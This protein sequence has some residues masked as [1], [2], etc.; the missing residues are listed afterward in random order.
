MKFGHTVAGRTCALALA[1]ALAACSG[2]NGSADTRLVAGIDHLSKR[3]LKA[4]VIEFKAAL[5]EAPD[6]PRTRFYLGRALLMSGDGVSAVVELRKALDLGHARAEVLPEL[7]RAMLLAGQPKKLLEELGNTD[8]GDGLEGADL[9]T[10]LASA[11]AQVGNIEQAAASLAVVLRQ[12]PDLPAAQL[13]KARFQL[14]DNLPDAA[15]ALAESV[16]RKEPANVDAHMLLGDIKLRTKGDLAGAEAAYQAALRADMNSLRAHSALITLYLRQKKLD[17]AHAQLEKLKLAH[18]SQFQTRLHEA[19]IAALDH[20]FPVARE[21]LQG[22]L[23]QAPESTD[24]LRLAGL[25]ESNMGNVRSARNYFT[26]AL[27]ND[28]A[29]VD[30]RVLLADNYLQTNQPQQA[31]DFLKDGLANERAPAAVLELAAK[32]SMQ[33]GDFGRARELFQ[34]ANKVTPTNTA[35]LTS[36]AVLDSSTG[37]VGGAM[38]QLESISIRDADTVADYALIS[39][40]VKQADFDG[41]LRAI[42]AMKAKNVKPAALEVLRGRVELQR[43]ARPAARAHFERA[44]ADEPGL[45]LAVLALA[46]LDLADGLLVEAQTRFGKLLQAE[47]QNSL[48]LL[49]S[50]RVMARAGAP[51]SKVEERLA[52]AVKAEPADMQIRVALID[53]LLS[54]RDGK[55]AVLAAQA[56][57]AV[58][59]NAEEILERLGRAHLLNGDVQQA[60]STYRKLLPLRPKAPEPYFMLSEAY[61]AANDTASAETMLRQAVAVAPDN[62]APYREQARQFMKVRKTEAALA[63]VRSFQKRQPKNPGG[64]LLESEI[65][66]QAKNND[67]GI[68]ALK[69]GLAAVDDTELAVRLYRFLLAT[70]KATEAGSLANDWL[71]RKPADVGF[72]RALG[73]MAMQ[74]RSYE[75]A[76]RHFQAVIKLDPN[77]A[78]ALNNLAWLRNRQGKSDSLAYAERAVAL[79]GNNLAYIDTLAQ[80]LVRQKQLPRAVELAK[81]VLRSPEGDVPLQLS[82]IDVLVQAGG[83]SALAAAELDKLAKRQAGS[84]PFVRS[85]INRLRKLVSG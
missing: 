35:I 19:Q 13:L 85:E 27:F 47:P 3:E 39:L 45:T 58:N 8:L 22:L 68:L 60:V 34:R 6:N 66:S 84:D 2:G 54:R 12:H 75:L 17:Q 16:L 48:A 55:A 1:F 62:L 78:P 74:S 71:K 21:L 83:Q 56:A 72:R 81:R 44:L 38:R 53:F 15:I 18:P 24:V 4:A 28:K 36:L 37:D 9:R 43:G 59:P 26:K 57:A 33:L 41:A 73:D 31:I 76:E 63:V 61:L 65:Q 51:N 10:S 5:Q 67:A 64:Y 49:E 25:V 29:R 11:Q 50:A 42:D 69:A 7:A 20:H 46:D 77:D 14:R 70:N 79:G 52:E 82:A 23:R 30:I 32:A 40:R 80:V